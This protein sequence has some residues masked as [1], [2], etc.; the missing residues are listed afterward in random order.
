MAGLNKAYKRRP[1]GYIRDFSPALWLDAADPSTLYQSNGGALASA[2]NDPVG[3]WLDKGPNGFHASQATSTFRPLLQTNS[4]NTRSG[5][6]S[7]GVDDYL[8]TALNQ[9]GVATTTWFM[10][11]KATGTGAFISNYN[12][13]GGLL[14]YLTSTK[15]G[16]DGRPH[17]G[18]YYSASQTFTS[19]TT[20]T[21]VVSYWDG[22]NMGSKKNNSSFATTAPVLSGN[23]ITTTNIALFGVAT[24]GVYY[25]GIIYEVII[26]NYLATADQIQ[27]ISNYLNSKWSI[28]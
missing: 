7:D 27:N 5:I 23:I 6:I 25:S 14:T 16:V 9:N 21:L 11:A 18:N 24:L 20:T 12:T 8:Q 1:N 15:T 28:Y 4:Q 22:T 17:G 10:V 2:N 3:Y 19:T 26:L 13:N